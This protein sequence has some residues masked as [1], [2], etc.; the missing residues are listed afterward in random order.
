MIY[1][2]LAAYSFSHPWFL[3]SIL[4]SSNRQYWFPASQRLPAFL[5]VIC[6]RDL[7]V[8]LKLKISGCPAASGVSRRAKNP[9]K[10]INTE[11]RWANVG[12]KKLRG[13]QNRAKK[14]KMSQEE[15]KIE[16]ISAKMGTI[17]LR[18]A[19]I[20]MKSRKMRSTKARNI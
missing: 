7:W 19:N 13:R 16:P 12:P 10:V 15:F 11:P 8:Q 6:I 18:Q 2:F 20:D 3:N 17:G 9:A 5:A 1:G 4:I 14:A